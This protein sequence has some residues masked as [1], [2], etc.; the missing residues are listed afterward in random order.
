MSPLRFSLCTFAALA[1]SV[2]VEGGQISRNTGHRTVASSTLQHPTGK[3]G[4]RPAPSHAA[5]KSVHMA[6]PRNVK[7]PKVK[8]VA[9]RKP[10]RAF[11]KTVPVASK[12]TPR[13]TG[14]PTTTKPTTTGSKTTKPT[15]TTGSNTTRPI[16]TTGSGTTTTVVGS[17][18]NTTA[19]GT[20]TR[21]TSGQPTLNN[22]SSRAYYRPHNSGGYF[23]QRYHHHRGNYYRHSIHH[24]R[25]HHR[26]TRQQHAV[27]G[28]V[29]NTTGMGNTGMVQVRV[30]PL[31]D[32]QF[33]Y[34]KPKNPLQAPPLHN[35]KVLNTTKIEL[36]VGNQGAFKRAR[37]TISRRVIG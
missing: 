11:R 12:T 10:T 13:Q 37:S 8:V 21:T 30:L 24:S 6:R 32:T 16:T 22:N 5:H 9:I 19:S 35:F 26:F 33:R 1:L 29:M 31:S 17:N 7:P 34:P 15:T 25:R 36:M 23:N 2:N 28:I 27:R 18:P 14:K 20:T 4:A 3:G